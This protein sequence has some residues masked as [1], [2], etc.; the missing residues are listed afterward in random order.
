VRGSLTVGP[1]GVLYGT[2]FHDGNGPCVYNEGVGLGCGTVFQLTPP[3]TQGGAWT[4]TIIYNF[5]ATNGDGA[6]PSGTL[7]VGKNGV[8]YGTAEFGG[9]ATV[10]T[11]CISLGFPAAAL[12]SR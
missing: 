1:N 5:T 6:W 7:A 12:H 8:L 3:A 2:A 9:S 10:D 11:L 4:E